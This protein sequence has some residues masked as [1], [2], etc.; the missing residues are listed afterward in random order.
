MANDLNNQDKIKRV[1]RLLKTERNP[2]KIARIQ[3]ELEAR[4]ALETGNK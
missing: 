4:Q 2:V 3:L 1:K